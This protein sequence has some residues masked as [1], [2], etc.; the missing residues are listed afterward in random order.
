VHSFISLAQ[1]VSLCF[2]A[3]LRLSKKL[4]RSHE[5]HVIARSGIALKVFALAVQIFRFD[6]GRSL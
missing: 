2:S 3:A 5:M 4:S 6:F 1:F